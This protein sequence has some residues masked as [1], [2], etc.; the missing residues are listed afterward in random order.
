MFRDRI[1]LAI[2]RNLR[3]VE[4]A[5]STGLE[6][7]EPPAPSPPVTEGIVRLVCWMAAETEKSL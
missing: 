4:W 7:F 2:V 6:R 5:L 3:I 1:G